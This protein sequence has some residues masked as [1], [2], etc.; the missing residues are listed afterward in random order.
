LAVVL[1]AEWRLAIGMPQ[2]N[3]K[4]VRR[5]LLSELPVIVPE[6]KAFEEFA[7]RDAGPELITVTKSRLPLN[8]FGHAFIYLLPRCTSSFLRS[9][10][11]EILS[12]HLL[13]ILCAVTD[14]DNQITGIL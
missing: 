11:T 8:Y 1:E 12:F 3:A 10:S 9:Q 13:H 4:N 2:V 7:S 5:E 6:T 14:A